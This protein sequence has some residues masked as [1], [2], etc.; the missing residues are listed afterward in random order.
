MK[1]MELRNWREVHRYTQAALASDLDVSRQTVVGWE[2]AEIPLPRILELALGELERRRNV[3]GK[4]LS[5][6]EQQRVRA[7]ARAYEQEMDS[8][9]T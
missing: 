7:R 1:G 4:R 6:A 9:D 8:K 2:K 5:A 3:D